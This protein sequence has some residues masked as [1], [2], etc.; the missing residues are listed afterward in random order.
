VTYAAT[1]GSA[2]SITSTSRSATPSATTGDAGR[3]AT[4]CRIASIPL[5]SARSTRT[6]SGS[7]SCVGAEPPRGGGTVPVMAN[8]RRRMTS[9]RPSR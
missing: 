5:G 3:A 2:Q 4:K 7:G 8:P 9:T 6:T 1:P